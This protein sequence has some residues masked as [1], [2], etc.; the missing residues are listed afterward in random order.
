MIVTLCNGLEHGKVKV[1]VEFVSVGTGCLQKGRVIMPLP[2]FN[3]DIGGGKYFAWCTDYA[4]AS[5]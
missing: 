2:L 3:R 5:T 1:C 4:L